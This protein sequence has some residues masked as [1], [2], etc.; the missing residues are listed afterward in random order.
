M[1]VHAGIWLGMVPGQLWNVVSGQRELDAGGGMGG[2]VSQPTGGETSGVRATGPRSAG[3]AI[4]PRNEPG[5]ASGVAFDPASGHYLNIN[6]ARPSPVNA[7]P[8]AVQ[9]QTGAPF[10]SQGATAPTEGVAPNQMG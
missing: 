9:G 6:T 5:N 8:G 4:G 10:W 2:V 7:Q 1:G 3:N